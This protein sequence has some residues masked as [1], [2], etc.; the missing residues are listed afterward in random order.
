MYDD[1]V[2]VDK[3]YYNKLKEQTTWISVDDRLP[4]QY[5]DV[6]VLYDIG[7]VGVNWTNTEN[8][9]VSH[10]YCK[11]THWMPLPSTEE[12]HDEDT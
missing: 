1:T 7:R 3:A 6:I 9:F 5:T 4:E 12:P 2:M 11:V 8:E 10:A